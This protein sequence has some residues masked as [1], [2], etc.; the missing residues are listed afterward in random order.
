MPKS[1]PHRARA[2]HAQ[3]PAYESPETE[4]EACGDEAAAIEQLKQPEPSILDARNVLD[5]ASSLIEALRMMADG[6][7]LEEHEASALHRMAY[8]IQDEIKK[9]AKSRKRIEFSKP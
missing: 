4:P 2:A 3:K 5:D 6:A 9:A 7:D 1:S 8:R